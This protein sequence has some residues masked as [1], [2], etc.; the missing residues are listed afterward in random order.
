M[1]H[2]NGCGL[3]MQGQPDDAA[4]SPGLPAMTSQETI[5]A[6]LRLPGGHKPPM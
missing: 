1:V 5:T 6:H 3:T 2:R 4:P